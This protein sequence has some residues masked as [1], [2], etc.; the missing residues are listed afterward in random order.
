M[1][2]I[3][4]YETMDNKLQQLTH[5]LYDEGLEKGRREAENLVAAARDEAAKIVGNARV[6]ADRMRRE[7]QADAEEMRRNT[8]TELN[9]AGGQVVSR[10]K[11]AVREMVSARALDGAVAAAALDPAFVREI[12]LAAV[13][14]WRE[15]APLTAILPEAMRKELDGKFERSVLGG[16][17]LEVRFSE[18]VES[19]FRLAPRDGG[20][21]IDFTDEAFD[22]LLRGYLRPKVDEIL[23]R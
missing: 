7:A 18:G 3:K 13:K 1:S 9:I 22:S 11:A 2:M 10:L 15:G 20:Y 14:N 17:T 5:K 23:Y 6:E 12:L 21:Y 19:G 4:N 16:E 8:M